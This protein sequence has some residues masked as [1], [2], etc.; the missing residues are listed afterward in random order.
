MW[1]LATGSLGASKMNAKER[2]I[3][4]R[5]LIKFTAIYSLD[6]AEIVGK[7]VCVHNN[8]ILSC[9][10]KIIILKYIFLE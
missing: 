4:E 2:A 8:G 7:D 3:V 5:F 10:P 1:S 6:I 9:R